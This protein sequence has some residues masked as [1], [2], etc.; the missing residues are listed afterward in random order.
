ME[1]SANDNFAP[2]PDNGSE[3][4]TSRFDTT[5]WNGEDMSPGERLERYNI[6]DNQENDALRGDDSSFSAQQGTT[7]VSAADEDTFHRPL[8]ELIND[9][10][11]DVAT[12]Y[13]NSQIVAK[14]NECHPQAAWQSKDVTWRISNAIKSR[15]RVTGESY[16]E[17][18]EQLNQAKK[19]NNVPGYRASSSGSASR[20]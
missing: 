9:V 14:V 17:I 1:S 19:A 8:S 3:Q 4:S 10:I 12:R 18:R 15:S 11:F 13:S 7:I 5:G 2:T 20:R 6:S 16:P